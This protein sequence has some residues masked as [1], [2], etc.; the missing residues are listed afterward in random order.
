MTLLTHIFTLLLSVALQFNALSPDATGIN[1]ETIC[2]DSQGNL[3]FGGMDGIT[4]YDGSR[5]TVFRNNVHDSGSIQDNRI[6]KLICADDGRI[7]AAHISGLSVFDSASG[8]FRNFR[9]P[10]GTITDIV[11]LADKM[12]I[13][14]V[15]HDLW[16]FDSGTE[17]FHRDGIPDVLRKQPCQ[18]LY[19]AGSRIYIGTFEGRVFSATRDLASVDEFPEAFGHERINSILL[20]RKSQLWVGTE[21]NGLWCVPAAGGAPVQFK[22]SP[23]EG[24]LSFDCVRVLCLDGNGDLWVGTKNGL[25]VF[26]DGRFDVFV[27]DYYESRS[28]THDSVHEIFCDRQGIMW[29]GTYF[30]GVCYYTP[31]SAPFACIFP[32]PGE[33]N[34]NGNVISDITEDSDGSLWIGTNSEGLNHMLRNGSFE[35]I[36]GLE[37]NG[38][39]PIDVKCIYESPVTGRLFI[40]SDG[41]PMSVLDRKNRKLKILGADSPR[42]V[43]A[44]ESNGKGGLFIGSTSGLFAFD[45]TSGAFSKIL[46]AGDITN[47]KSLKVDSGGILWIGKKFGVSALDWEAGK[48]LELPA[49]LSE[50]HY[51]EDFFEDNSGAVWIASNAGL[52][53]YSPSSGEIRSFTTQDGLPDNVIHGIEEDYAGNMWVSTNL[54]LCRFNPETGD[55]W[56]FTVSDGLPGN[57]FMAYAHCLTSSGEMYFGGLLGLVHFNP[58]AVSRP[59]DAVAPIISCVEVN[60]RSIVPADGAVSLKPSERDISIIFSAPDYISGQNGRFFYKMEGMDDDWHAAG[61]ERKAVYHGLKHGHYTFLLD[62]SNSSGVRS[63]VPC[64]L[65]IRVLA[66]WWET[67]AAKSALAILILLALVFIVSWLVSRKENE[68]KSEMERTRNELLRDFSLEFVSLGAKSSPEESSVADIFDKSDEDFMRKAMQVVRKNMDNPDF[69]VEGFAGEMSMSK[70]SLHARVK[71]LFGV[72][73]LRFIKTVRFNEACRLILEKKHSIAEIGYMVGFASPSYFASAF[74]NFVGCTPSDYLTRNQNRP[75]AKTD[76]R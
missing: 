26:R 17:K 50:V 33:A 13:T 45:E 32:K 71:T 63:D 52:L 19:D 6:Y 21:G 41:T 68:Y 35:H 10:S 72:S 43:Y 37:N 51:V 59:S 53:K 34:F 58:D 57:R 8:S 18:S 61:M 28:I 60:G 39:E 2:Q 56:T 23:K 69:S 66:R 36:R 30:G 16:V 48:V 74:H 55:K 70:S 44:I 24:S 9:S 42:N 49:R 47:I 14:I 54:G 12:F 25:N 67:A 38:S 64:R 40:G 3:W 62:Y 76:E 11:Q 75:S 15:G 46:M 4:K 29:I 7:W 73:P 31:H 5:F 22:S 27:H 65:Q 1:T 20:D